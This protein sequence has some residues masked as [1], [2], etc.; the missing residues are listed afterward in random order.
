MAFISMAG[1][2]LATMSAV[3]AIGVSLYS[4][5][6]GGFRYFA[7]SLLMIYRIGL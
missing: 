4:I 3:L 2:V 5:A 1:F 6:T 7:P